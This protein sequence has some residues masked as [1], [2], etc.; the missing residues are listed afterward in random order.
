MALDPKDFGWCEDCGRLWP[1]HKGR[2]KVCRACGERLQKVSNVTEPEASQAS[3]ENWTAD[4]REA[5]Q[6]GPSP[7]MAAKILG[8][9]RATVDHLVNDGV[10]ERAEYERDGHKLVVISWR[11]I[12]R[13]GANKSAMGS[14]TG[15]PPGRPS[16]A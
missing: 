6:W 8:C 14:Y 13:A 1:A 3:F 5:G 15:K 10:L 11:S 7:A 4:V 9:G 2:D 12:A 16:L